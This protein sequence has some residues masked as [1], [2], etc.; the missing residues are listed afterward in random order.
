M[1]SLAGHQGKIAA[2]VA[3]AAILALSST[4]LATHPRAGGGTPLRFPLV[5]AYEACSA[6]NTTHVAPY[7][8]PS[9]SPPTRFSPLLTMGTAGAGTGSV[10]IDVLC[11]DGQVPACTP[12]DGNDTEDDR[13]IISTSDV[14]CAPGAVAPG[15]AFNGSDYTNPLIARFRLRVTDHANATS[16]AATT[17]PTGS[18]ANPCLTATVQDFNFNAPVSCADNGGANGAV[19]TLSTTFDALEPGT[20]RELQRQVMD[21][22]SFD[23]LDA[24][25]DG[26]IAPGPADDPLGLGCPAVCGSG[27]ESQFQKIGFFNN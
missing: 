19:C 4:A 22:L 5:P 23:L 18:G 26:S 16:G 13:L 11:T 27:D 17:C 14:R 1:R 9:C 2:L 10:R 12:N 7:A 25:P 6:P 24:G 21:L 15:C 3:V 20:V 8:Y